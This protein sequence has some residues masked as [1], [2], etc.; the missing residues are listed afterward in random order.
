[1]RHLKNMMT[2]PSVTMMPI[3]QETMERLAVAKFD[4]GGLVCEE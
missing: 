2:K 3:T 4:P 1:M